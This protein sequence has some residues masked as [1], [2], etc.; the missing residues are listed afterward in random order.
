MQ[1][2]TDSKEAAGNI[3][4]NHRNVPQCLLG[5][6]GRYVKKTK[7]KSCCNDSWTV[8]IAICFGYFTWDSVVHPL[9]W[10]TKFIG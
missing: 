3:H 8:G 5:R 9:C 4:R 1:F 7:R 10:E 2:I 6:A